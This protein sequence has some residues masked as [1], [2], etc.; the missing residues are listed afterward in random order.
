MLEET[1]P[2]QSEAEM[3]RDPRICPLV[4][5]LAVSFWF[6]EQREMGTKARRV[7]IERLKLRF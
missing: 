3:E 4:E 2:S 1:N 5:S 7:L 6:V